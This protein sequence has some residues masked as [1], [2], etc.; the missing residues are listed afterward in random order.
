M[1]NVLPTK[2]PEG[3][4]KYRRVEAWKNPRI[5]LQMTAREEPFEQAVRLIRKYTPPERKGIAMI[6]RFDNILPF[7][8]GKYSDLPYPDLQWFVISKR[9]RSEVLRYFAEKKP[10]FVFVDTDIGKNIATED[11]AYVITKPIK[12]EYI[13]RIGRMKLFPALWRRVGPDYVLKEQTPMISVWER[14]MK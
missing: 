5:R 1:R 13:A 6:S 7:A 8:A 9:E 14:K 11:P 10:R 3:P 4:K 2:I 12:D